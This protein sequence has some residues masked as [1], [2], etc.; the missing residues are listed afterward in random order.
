MLQL[1]EWQEV[2]KQDLY[3]TFEEAAIDNIPS[4]II[5]PKGDMTNLF[6]FSKFKGS[7]FEP[8]IEEQD[9]INNGTNKKNLHKNC[10]SLE[11]WIEKDF[12]NQKNWKTKNSADFTIYTPGSNAGV[13][14]FN[15]IIF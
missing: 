10:K 7:D 12:Q 8:W 4:I 1:L 11:K 5:D 15:F 14:S 3:F 6:Y 2:E 9:A 13:Q